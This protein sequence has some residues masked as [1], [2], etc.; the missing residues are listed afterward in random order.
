MSSGFLPIEP[1][2]PCHAPV[3]NQPAWDLA[4]LYPLQGHWS[5]E[6]YLELTD[7]T[8]RLIEYTSGQIEVLPMPS[9]EH[10]LILTYLF[11]ML[12]GFV[13]K[14]QLGVVV[15]SGTRV[16]I[17]PEKYREPDLVFKYAAKHTRSNRRYLE[18]A[19][20]VMEIVSDDPVSQTR[21]F[22]KKVLDYAAGGIPEY[23]IVAPQ[24][25]QITVYALVGTAYEQHGLF[26]EGEIATSKLLADFMV[27]VAEVFA[28]G[29][30]SF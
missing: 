5:E 3:L 22:E 30:A 28:A 29:K 18:S 19:D 24:T 12:D 26:S 7:K 6:D 9:I 8:R 10:Q 27:D 15:C 25:R 13:M 11:R 1:P 14:R 23:W 21:D 4:L 16:Y 20:L 17:Q 2:D